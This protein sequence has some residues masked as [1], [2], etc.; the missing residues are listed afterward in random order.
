MRENVHKVVDSQNCWQFVYG[1]DAAAAEP[2]PVPRA[3][4]AAELVQAVKEKLVSRGSLGIRGVSR[5]FRALDDNGDRKVSKTE[6][7][8]GLM[9]WQI[10]LTPDQGDVL[11]AAFDRDGSGTINFDELLV[12]L[13]GDLN[14]ARLSWIKAAYQKLDKNG[15]G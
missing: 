11:F 9:D 8:E 3:P 4:T 2:V 5:M 13:R 1:T 10:F 7:V 6:L 12:A 14:E 15:D